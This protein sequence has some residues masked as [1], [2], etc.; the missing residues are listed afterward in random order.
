MSPGHQNSKP[1]ALITP[2]GTKDKNNTQI[3][4]TLEKL[5]K[6]EKELSHPSNCLCL[7]Y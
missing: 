3:Q 6:A 4:K 5:Y 1:Q 7:K 2:Q